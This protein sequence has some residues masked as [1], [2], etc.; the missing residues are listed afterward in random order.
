MYA[1]LHIIFCYQWIY[2][3]FIFIRYYFLFAL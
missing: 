2:C 1:V 3:T